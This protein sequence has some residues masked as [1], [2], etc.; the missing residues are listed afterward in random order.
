M[1]RRQHGPEYQDAVGAEIRL[2]F[3]VQLFADE[4]EAGAWMA[5]AL[6]IL[7]LGDSVRAE[8]FGVD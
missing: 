5:P 3:C 6:E 2:G 7:T 1:S 8:D 4:D